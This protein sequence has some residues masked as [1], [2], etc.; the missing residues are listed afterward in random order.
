LTPAICWGSR[1]GGRRQSRSNRE[2]PVGGQT[3]VSRTAYPRD[4]GQLHRQGGRLL[5]GEEP[6]PPTAAA[7]TR[8]GRRLRRHRLPFALSGSDTLSGGVLD[9][10]EQK[11]S[12]RG[13]LSRRQA[14]TPRAKVV[15]GAVEQRRP[16]RGCVGAVDRRHPCA[17]TCKAPSRLSSGG[18]LWSVLRRRPPPP[19]VAAATHAV[20]C[21]NRRGLAG[22]PFDDGPAPP[23][24]RRL[25]RP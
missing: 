11:H 23:A 20:C 25:C 13:C 17:R 5:T 3:Y 22:G 21:S 24:R 1:K 12:V 18:T 8:A 19:A 4:R 14:A 6:P 9:V 2:A 10:V 16:V 15:R 7:A